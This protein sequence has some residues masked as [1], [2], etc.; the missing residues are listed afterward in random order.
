METIKFYATQDDCDGWI[1]ENALIREFDSREAA[2]VY[3]S[4]YLAKYLAEENKSVRI[5][6]GNFGD[7]WIK[8]FDQPNPDDNF[9][10]FR[11]DQLNVLAPGQNPGQIGQY[12]ITPVPEVL[13][14]V[15]V[16]SEE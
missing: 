6:A 10:P 1:N 13:I 5:E 8:S 4:N 3:L 11:Y 7:C 14:A 12:W 9:S 16:E 2:A 15:E